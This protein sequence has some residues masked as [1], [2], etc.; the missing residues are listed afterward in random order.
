MFFGTYTPKL[1]DKGRLILPAKFRDQLAGGLMVTRGQEHCLYVWPQAEVDRL[2]ERLR[3]APVSNKATR[4][5][6]RMFSSASSDE[7]PDKQGRITIPPKL[8][9]WASLH[10]DVVVIGAMNRLEIWDE[11]AWNAYS[12]EQEEAFA[13][14]SEEVIPGI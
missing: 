12:E 2:T 5:F 11:A 4:D 10:K 13:E 9:E 3:E 7:R 14:L 1:D 6:V 8:R